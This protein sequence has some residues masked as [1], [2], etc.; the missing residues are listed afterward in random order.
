MIRMTR[1]IINIF[2]N[3]CEKLKGL[4]ARKEKRIWADDAYLDP[5]PLLIHQEPLRSYES[6]E[7]YEWTLAMF[8]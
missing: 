5:N 3:L 8:Y 4:T 6:Y 2:S 1:T 7:S